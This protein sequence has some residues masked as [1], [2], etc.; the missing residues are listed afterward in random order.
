MLESLDFLDHFLPVVTN[1]AVIFV[2]WLGVNGIMFLIYFVTLVWDLL[3]RISPW[4]SPEMR[5]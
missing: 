4:M 3:T 2:V 5:L 1:F